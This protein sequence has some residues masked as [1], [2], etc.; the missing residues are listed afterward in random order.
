MLLKIFWALI[1]AL[2][3]SL[4]AALYSRSKQSWSLVA[5]SLSAH[6]ARSWRLVAEDESSHALAISSINFSDGKHGLA[7]T[8]AMFMETDDG[9]LTWTERA[10]QESQALYSF[11][12]VN[13]ATGWAVGTERDAGGYRPVIMRTD[14]GGKVW[15]RQT[16]DVA[17]RPNARTART[18]LGVSFCNSDYGWAVGSELILHT[19]DGGETWEAQ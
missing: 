6:P 5:A 11:A 14:D 18:L 10:Y 16:V 15:R 4:A 7:L 3:L 17:A 1:L 9:G 13:R 2:G 8:P 19:A 12:F